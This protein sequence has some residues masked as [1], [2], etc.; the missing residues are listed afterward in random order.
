MMDMVLIVSFA[1]WMEFHSLLIALNLITSNGRQ[2]WVELPELRS[3]SLS[4]LT[5]TGIFLAL[6]AR[7]FR[8]SQDKLHGLAAG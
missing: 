6:G 7:P 3:P 1:Y 4:T 2:Y 5:P 8:F